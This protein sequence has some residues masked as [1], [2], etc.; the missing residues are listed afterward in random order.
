MSAPE[1]GPGDSPFSQCARLKGTFPFRIGTTSYIIPDDILPNLEYLR[2]RVDD[3]ELVLFESDEF[4]NLPSPGAVEQ[5]GRLGREAN[6]T[7]TVHLPLDIRLGSADEAE[8]QASVGKCLR[9]IERMRPVEPFGW[10]LH[11]HGEQR[12]DPPT[13]DLPRWR[14]QNRR[15]LRELLAGGLPRRQLC[16]ESLDYDFDLV[17]GLVEEFDLSVCLDI[18]HLLVQRR[19]VVAHLD[20]WLDRARVFHVHGVN[21]EGADHNALDHIP[22]GIL[23]TLA[24]RLTRLP[25]GDVRVMTMEIFGQ[26]D[27]ERSRKTV[28]ER[29]GTWRK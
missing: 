11:L 23:E 24:G 27:F 12:G 7:Y 16:V 21:P 13:T 22:A 5:I 17:A 29:L 20:R 1:N 8:R 28:A 2:D 19:D 25:T 4:S 18:G 6:L 26:D 9:V 14:S 10:I 15:S 3:V